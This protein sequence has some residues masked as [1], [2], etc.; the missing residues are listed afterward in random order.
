MTLLWFGGGIYVDNT[1][2]QWYQ[3]NQNAWKQI[4]QIRGLWRRQWR[5]C[6][7]SGG[8]YRLDWRRLDG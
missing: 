1:L 6:P 8:D 7:F 3:W 2:G 4:A 5:D